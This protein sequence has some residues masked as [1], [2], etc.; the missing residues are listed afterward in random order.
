MFDKLLKAAVNIA[1][2]PVD[3]AA[4]AVTGLGMA[5]DRDEPYTVEK[6]RRIKKQLDD[7][8]R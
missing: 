8:G 5:T 4:D 7:A 3:I 1:T 2:L 6:V